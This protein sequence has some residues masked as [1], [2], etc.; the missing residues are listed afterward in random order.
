M[1][2]ESFGRLGSYIYMEGVVKLVGKQG[3]EKGSR[4]Q[5]RHVMR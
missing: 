5:E 4:P 2:G 3:K 1:V